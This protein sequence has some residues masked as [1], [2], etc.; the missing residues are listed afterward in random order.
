MPLT[1]GYVYLLADIFC[2]FVALLEFMH[3]SV[4][5]SVVLAVAAKCSS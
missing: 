3:I 4:V 5:F 1:S 2:M